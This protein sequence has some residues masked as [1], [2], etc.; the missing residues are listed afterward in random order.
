MTVNGMSAANANDGPARPGLPR[1]D[2]LP[3]APGRKWR[4]SRLGLVIAAIVILAMF[5]IFFI[6][7]A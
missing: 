4:R 5:G 7:D 1:D 3:A 2:R 6:A